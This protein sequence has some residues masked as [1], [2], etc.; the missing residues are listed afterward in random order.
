M[1]QKIFPG[2]ALREFKPL[3]LVHA[4]LVP[5][6]LASSLLPYHIYANPLQI[7]LS[8]IPFAQVL[9]LAIAQA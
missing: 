6:P 4:I 8:S 7:A 3:L 1:L 9:F 2:G 5:A